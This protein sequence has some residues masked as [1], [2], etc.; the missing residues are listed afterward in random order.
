M[1]KLG[2]DSQ[3]SFLRGENPTGFELIQYPSSL[4]SQTNSIEPR[5]N[6]GERED[7]QTVVSR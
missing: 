4:E 2:W 1:G 7:D 6:Q 5:R 3:L